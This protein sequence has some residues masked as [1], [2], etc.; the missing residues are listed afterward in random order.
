M[1]DPYIFIYRKHSASTFEKLFLK[2]CMA[3]S[4]DVVTKCDKMS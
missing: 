3:N 4:H 2:L 1:K